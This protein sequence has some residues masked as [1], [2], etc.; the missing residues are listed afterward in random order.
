MI[1]FTS[2]L[3]LFFISF[4]PLLSFFFFRSILE[5]LSEDQ[6]HLFSLFFREKNGNMKQPPKGGLAD[7]KQFRNNNDATNYSGE[8]KNQG[9]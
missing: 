7:C 4:L 1:Q 5:E 8:E 6:Q 3:F 2:F 9:N